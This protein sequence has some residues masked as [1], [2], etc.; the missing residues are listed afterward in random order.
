MRILSVDLGGV[1][2]GL[3]VCD[4]DELLASPVTVLEERNREHLAQRV[5]QQMQELRAEMAVVG[6]PLNM[7]G[8][9]GEKAQ[10]A[11]RFAER[12]RELTR[13]P[14]ELQDERGTTISAHAALNVTNTRGKKRK[15]VV[16]KVAAVIILECFMEKRRLAGR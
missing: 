8:S 1:R 12:L 2:T 14:V 11:Q 13:L 5:A 9:F 7:D 16:D 6:L 3:A 4:K 15:A 10:D